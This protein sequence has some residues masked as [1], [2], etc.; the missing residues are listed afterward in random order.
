MIRQELWQS[1][2]ATGAPELYVLYK[3]ACNREADH[4]SDG[5][6]PGYSGQILQ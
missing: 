4:V 3:E 1:F 6:G 5:A 2:L